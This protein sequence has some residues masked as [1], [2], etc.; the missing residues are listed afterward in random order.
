VIARDEVLETAHRELM[1][2]LA[3]L[4]ERGQALKHYQ[5]LAELMREALGS[6]PAPETQALYEELRHGEDV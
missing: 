1:R 3:R 2:C 5:S 6:D 4:G